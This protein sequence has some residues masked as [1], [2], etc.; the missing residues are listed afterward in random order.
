MH[1]ETK[2]S[3]QKTNLIQVSFLTSR[4]RDEGCTL[5][6]LPLIVQKVSR[7]ESVGRLPLVLVKQH[8][9]QIGNDRSSLVVAVISVNNYRRREE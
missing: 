2:V 3:E 8:R 1:S 6:E 4:E 5:P 7:V 9:G